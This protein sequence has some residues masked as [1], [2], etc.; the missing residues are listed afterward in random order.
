QGLATAVAPGQEVLI[1]QSVAG[2]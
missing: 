1:I 2:G